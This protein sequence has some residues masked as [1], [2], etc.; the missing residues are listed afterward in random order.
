MDKGECWSRNLDIQDE[1]QEM[2]WI[3]LWNL[4]DQGDLE[5]QVWKMESEGEN[6]HSKSNM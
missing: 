6:C 3:K 4:A 1:I 5:W 2:M